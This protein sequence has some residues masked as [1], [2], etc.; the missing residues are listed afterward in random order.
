MRR[1]RGTTTWTTTGQRE[2]QTIERLR[3]CRGGR[4]CDADADDDREHDAP[5]TSG[6]GGA[7]VR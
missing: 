7:P 3:G 4:Y 6:E 5:V 2:K 1:A